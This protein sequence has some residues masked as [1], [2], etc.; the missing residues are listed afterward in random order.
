MISSEVVN[1]FVNAACVPIGPGVGSHQDGN[2]EAANKLLQSYPDIT[3]ENIYTAAILGESG[4][5]KKFLAEDPASA[6]QK[7]GPR[8]WDALTYLCFSRYLR[9][10][11]DRSEGFELTAKILLDAG[12]DANAG[13]Y[14]NDHHPKPEWEPVLYG[15]AGVAH[16]AG[17][18]GLL[19]AHGADPNDVEVAYHSPE[20]YDNA[21]LQVL[22]ESGKLTQASLAMMLLRKADFHDRD[23]M[24]L[25]LDGGADPNSITMWGYT[26][27][28]Q[29]LRRDNGLSN[30]EL[31]LH[32][33]ADPL[34]PNTADGHSALA[35]AITRGRADVLRSLQER[36][37]NLELTEIE[38]LLYACVMDD[39]ETVKNITSQQPALVQV[40]L[41][42]GGILLSE[43]AGTSNAAGVKQLLDLGV[44]VTA[45]YRGDG[46]FG[47]PPNSTALHVAAWKGWPDTVQVLIE[48]GAPVN[49]VDGNGQTPLQLAIRACVDSYWTYRRNTTSIELLLKA[50][51]STKGISIPTGYDEAD[52][53]LAEK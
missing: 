37:I 25:L 46:Y 3:S 51:A 39:T 1:A 32:H 24:K 40:L 14:E 16:H 22:I 49:A 44:P 33:G 8:N 17:V 42:Y 2:I 47:I 19:V 30:I 11:K 7:G 5:V 38:K 9:L 35:F 15:A 18:T 41:N 6:T 20:T 53:L 4:T 36:G 43:F 45:I 29:A 12:A 26:A 28:H 10:D 27:L 23:G 31:L 48:R 21:A 13:F 34:L 52:K 50:G